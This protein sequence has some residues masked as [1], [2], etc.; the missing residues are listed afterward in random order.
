MLLFVFLKSSTLTRR[1]TSIKWSVDVVLFLVPV[2]SHSKP[3]LSLSLH[4]SCSIWAGERI[5]TFG[6]A[7]SHSETF[8]NAFEVA[9]RLFC[10]SQFNLTVTLCY[11]YASRTAAVKQYSVLSTVLF[12]YLLFYHEISFYIVLNYFIFFFFFLILSLPTIYI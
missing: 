1:N 6:R 11:I 8:I 2:P 12:V 10:R 4:S 7:A 3:D 5:D 9:F